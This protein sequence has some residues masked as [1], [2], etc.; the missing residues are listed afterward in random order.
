MFANGSFKN[1]KNTNISYAWTAAIP[2]EGFR[3]GMFALSAA[4]PLIPKV[5]GPTGDSGSNTG[6]FLN[7]H[8]LLDSL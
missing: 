5:Y 3:I 4:G 6:D 8:D 7:V 2:S 1:Y